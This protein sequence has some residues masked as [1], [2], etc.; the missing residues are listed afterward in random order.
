M[1]RGYQFKRYDA[2]SIIIIVLLFIISYY[3]IGSATR[4]NSIEG[5]DYLAKKQLLGFVI[6]FILMLI[7]SLIDYKFISKFAVLFYIINVLM[8][9]AVFFIGKET[10]GA[11]RWIMIGSFSIQPSEFS[12]FLMIIVLAKYFDKFKEKI[13][14]LYI[15]IPSLIII[16]VPFLLIQQQPNLSTSLVLLFI[17]GLMLFGSGI[18]YKY[19]FAMLAIAVP[20]VLGIFWYIQQPDQILLKQYQV[21]RVMALL[22]PED[23]EMTTALQ[24]EN[25]IQAIGSGQ[26]FG[27]GL[28]NGKLNQYNYLP[29]SQTDF[30]FAIIGEEFGFVGCTTVLLLL[31]LLL[32]RVIFIGKDSPDQL[33]QLIVTGFVAMIMFH[34]FIN[35][36]VTT[37][38]VPNTGL[39]LP[40]ISSGLSALWANMISLGLILN[41]SM[42]RKLS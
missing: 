2:I 36:G 17:Y 39:P 4:A 11:G 25:S 18:S 33:G 41:L 38:I 29:E 34:T 14:K 7:V 40:F 6:G 30:I 42:Q 19:I 24:T 23:Y 9:V 1:F 16:A 3:A 13:N 22:H 37:N 31:F 32:I 28:Y 8:L 5:T 15:I 20:L 10:N 12:K 26:L 27:K 35:V 21:D